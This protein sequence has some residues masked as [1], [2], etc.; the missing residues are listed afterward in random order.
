V[1]QAT[2]LRFEDWLKNFSS[3]HERTR[4][5]GL[6]PLDQRDYLAARNELARVLLKKQNRPL[7]AGAKTRQHLRVL[8][9]FPVAIHLPGS[10]AHALTSELWPGGFTAIVPPLGMPVDRL[11]YALAVNKDA[12]RIEGWSRVVSE[13]PAGGSTRLSVAFE[14]LAPIDAERVE[15]AVFDAVLRSFGPLK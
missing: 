7:P 12:E 5:G 3:L 11:K 4:A 9:A 8:A 6:S 14:T 2:E 15:F 13:S 10:V 1:R